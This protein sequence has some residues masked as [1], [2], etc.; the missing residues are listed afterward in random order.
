[1]FLFVLILSVVLLTV[2]VG[3]RIFF[4]QEEKVEG[5]PEDVCFW[6]VFTGLAGMMIFWLLWL[7]LAA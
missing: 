2:G 3:G 6:D 5:V 4:H 1:M 7:L